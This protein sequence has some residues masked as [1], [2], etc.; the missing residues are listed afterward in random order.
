MQHGVSNAPNRSQQ[1]RVNTDPF[2]L[3]GQ[4]LPH[5]IMKDM[6]PYAATAMKIWSLGSPEERRSALWTIARKNYKSTSQLSRL[7]CQVS[8]NCFMSNKLHFK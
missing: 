3:R 4:Y 5:V 8:Q 7:A 1:V 6:D 2:S